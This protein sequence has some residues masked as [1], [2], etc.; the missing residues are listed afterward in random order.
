M[1][2]VVGDGLALGAEEVLIVHGSADGRVNLGMVVHEV[3]Q[4]QLLAVDALV[5]PGSA[6]PD[7]IS[8]YSGTAAEV[9]TFQPLSIPRRGSR[10]VFMAAG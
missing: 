6:E 1:Y 8:G 4:A 5:L 2:A 10:D 7:V 3:S 9:V